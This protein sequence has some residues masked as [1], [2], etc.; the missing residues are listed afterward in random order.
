MAIA[1]IESGV[2]FSQMYGKLAGN[3]KKTDET[4]KG[5]SFVDHLISSNE[6]LITPP[7]QTS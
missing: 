7:V 2:A 3:G 4:T 1:G 5:S 6:R